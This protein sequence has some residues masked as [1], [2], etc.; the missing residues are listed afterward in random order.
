MDGFAANT[1]IPVNGW[2]ATEAPYLT[3]P[4][5]WDSDVWFHLT[6]GTGWVSFAGVRAEPSFATGTDGPKGG[7]RPVILLSECEGHLVRR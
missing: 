5:P 7:G 1:I 3:N 2:V 4:D 6:N